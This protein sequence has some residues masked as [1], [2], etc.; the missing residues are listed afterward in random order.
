MSSDT[1]R[2]GPEGDLT[3][4]AVERA[5]DLPPWASR[6]LLQ[7]FFHERMQPYHDSHEDVG[8][9]LD[10]AF[11]PPPGGF[12]L[13]ARVG[14][15]LAGA[16]TVLRTGMSGYVPENLLLFIAVDPDLRNRGIGRSL[17]E[18]IVATCDGSIKLHVEPD[19]PARRLYERCGFAAKY[20]EMR[21][22][23]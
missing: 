22:S 12:V 17:M 11:S 3:I 6:E 8:R 14:D 2:F 1:T 19:N 16:A 23:R 15:R 13:A 7:R 21:C 4:V 18:R 10:Y 20:V 5:E 9:G